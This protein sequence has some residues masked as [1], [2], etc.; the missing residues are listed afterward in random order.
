MFR[1]Q[2][3]ALAQLGFRTPECCHIGFNALDGLS[4]RGEPG[5]GFAEIFAE[6]YEERKTFKQIYAEIIK[7]LDEKDT[8]K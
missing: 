3:V 8:R 7:A 4:P 6:I 1:F 2:T 5:N